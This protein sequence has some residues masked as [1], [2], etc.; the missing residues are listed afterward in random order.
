MTTHPPPPT[1]PPHPR[2][3][4]RETIA[5]GKKYD[6]VR[7]HFEHPSGKHATREMV[8]H[9]GAVVVVPAL[10]DGRIVMMK[11]FRIAVN[12]W[13]WECCAGTIER[14]RLPDESFGQGEDPALCASREL[15]EETGYKPGKISPI[16]TFY[17]TPGLTDERMHAFFASDLSFVGQKLEEDEYIQ[18]ELLH[19]TQVWEMVQSGQI[20]D[21]ETLTALLLAARQGLIRSA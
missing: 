5:V 4:R 14:P 12:D 19:P 6:C 20:A 11:I 16:A 18:V 9:P 2:I 15:I 3:T 10:P 8:R 21:A 7:L 17:T 1:H 13:V